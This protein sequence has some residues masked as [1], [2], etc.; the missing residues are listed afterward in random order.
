M[1]DGSPEGSEMFGFNSSLLTQICVKREAGL[2]FVLGEV[3]NSTVCLPLLYSAMIHSTSTKAQEDI[4]RFFKDISVSVCF[5]IYFLASVCVSEER[6]CSAME[7][8]LSY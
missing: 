6:R 8:R 3:D 5:H 1:T 4:S 2:P 7:P